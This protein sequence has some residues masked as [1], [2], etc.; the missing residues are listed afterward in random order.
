METLHNKRHCNVNKKYDNK[1]KNDK[2]NNKDKKDKNTSYSTDRPMP[3]KVYFPT[4]SIHKMNDILIADTKVG[5]TTNK[6]KKTNT[7]DIS[8]YLVDE[9]NK[10][11]IYGSSGIFEMIHNNLFQ[12]YPV[13]KNIKEV[14]VNNNLK[15]LLDGSYMKRYD[16]PSYQIPYNHNIKYKTIRTY[17]NDVKS[18]IKFV[19][20]M[21]NE[22][23]CDF[24]MLISSADVTNNENKKIELNNFVKDEVLSFLSRLNLYR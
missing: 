12:L 1:D 14:T 6:T 17:K 9:S 21:E 2:K 10:I 5:S 19:I 11:L 4:I 16:T 20:E 24:Y 13:D 15:V 3:I 8:K 18:N 23:I 22:S 7:I